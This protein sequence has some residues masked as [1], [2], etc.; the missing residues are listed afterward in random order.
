MM[1]IIADIFGVPVHRAH[2]NP[3]SAA[4][5]GAYRALA[6]VLG[7]NLQDVLPVQE[8][9]RLA[10]RPDLKAHQE[11]KELSLIVESLERDLVIPRV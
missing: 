11:Y 9:L 2:D 8:G 4:L 6:C 10:A 5:G 3:N 1:Q 7:K